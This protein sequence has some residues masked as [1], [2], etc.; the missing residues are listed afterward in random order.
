MTLKF[1]VLRAFG[2]SACI[3]ALFALPAVSATAPAQNTLA[4]KASAKPESGSQWA[5][6][7][8][9][10]AEV[11]PARVGDKFGDWTF[12]CQAVSASENIC[13][14]V[15]VFADAQSKQRILVLTLRNVGTEKDRHLLMIAQAP[16][17][18]FLPVALTGKIDDG[19]PFDFAWQRCTRQGCQ[20]SLQISD[21]RETA[22]KAGKNMALGFKAQPEGQAITMTASLKG[23][24]R[25]LKEIG[26]K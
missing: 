15:Q 9:V 1:T 26:A 25:G 21:M 24:T 7:T 4:P 8:V 5:A 17:G 14:L 16:L 2:L 19:E 22:M 13:A 18:V 3:C 23:I 20:A 12:Q 6:S 10:P 11:V